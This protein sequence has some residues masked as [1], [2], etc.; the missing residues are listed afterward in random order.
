MYGARSNGH[1]RT[2]RVSDRDHDIGEVYVN[3]N[4]PYMIEGNSNFMITG[5][6][7]ADA[8]PHGHCKTFGDWL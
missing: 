5:D 1:N 2:F 6:A 4:A 8:D 3:G 7:D